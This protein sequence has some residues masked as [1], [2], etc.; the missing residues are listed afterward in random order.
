MSSERG[1]VIAAGRASEIVDLGGGR[2]LRRF[3]GDGNPGR[4]ADFME[5]ARR[6]GYPVPRIDAVRADGLVLEYIDGPTMADDAFGRPAVFAEHARTLARLHDELHRIRAP[7][8]GV[9]LHLDLHPRNVLISPRGPVVIDWANAEVGNAALDPAL[10]WVI[11]MTSA[12]PHGRAFAREFERH[13]DVESAR[14]A[15][16]EFRLGDANLTA[17]ER[18]RVQ[19]LLE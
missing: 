16:V 1:R 10:T 12:G 6:S 7:E 5:R 13:I 15:A 14:A 11:L 3:K 19:H 2:V 17:E 4:E 18:A 9:L 8:G